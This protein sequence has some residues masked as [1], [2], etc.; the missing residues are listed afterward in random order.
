MANLSNKAF[1]APDHGTPRALVVEEYGLFSS[2]DR[3]D[4]F[5]EGVAGILLKYWV[6]LSILS[7]GMTDEQVTRMNDQ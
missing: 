5:G 7:L 4:D 6:R 1:S 3:G 2:A